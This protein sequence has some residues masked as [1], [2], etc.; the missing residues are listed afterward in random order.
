M[1]TTTTKAMSLS[2]PHNTNPVSDI[3]MQ[4]VPEPLVMAGP[5]EEEVDAPW[6]RK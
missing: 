5:M 3:P 6:L 2:M 1:M 4:P